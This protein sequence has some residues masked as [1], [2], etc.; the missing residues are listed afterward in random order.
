MFLVLVSQVSSNEPL[1]LL[2]SEARHARNAGRDVGGRSRRH[3]GSD[4]SAV[5]ASYHLIAPRVISYHPQHP[6]GKLSYH[7][8]G[9]QPAGSI[10]ASN[11]AKIYS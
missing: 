10:S 1:I 4:T 6:A 8:P 3:G 7:G 2:R 5:T 9:P 11:I